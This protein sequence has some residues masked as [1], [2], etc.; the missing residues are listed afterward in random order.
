[1]QDRIFYSICFGFIVGVLVRSFIFINFYFLLFLV[2]LGSALILYFSLVKFKWGLI[3]AIFILALTLG[4]FRFQIADNRAPAVFESQVGHSVSLSGVVIDEPDIRQTN[5]KLTVEI[6]N[7]P[8]KTDVLVSA[9][10]DQ[11]FKYGDEINFTGKLKKPENFLTDQGKTF[12]YINYLRKDGILYL[13]NYPQIEIIS[14]NN[15]SKIKSALFFAKE[16]FLDEI[17]YIIPS[18]DSL[19]MGGLILGEKSDFDQTLR[20][21]FVNT[22]TIHI[23]ALSGYNVTIVAQWIM[24][25]FSLIPFVPKN[26]GISI[27]ILSIILFILM[28]GGSSTAIR[29]GIMATLALVARGTGRNYDVSRALVIAGVGMILLNPFVLVYDV[30]FQLSVL[31][32]VAVIFLSPKIEKYFMWMTEHFGLRE[33]VSLTV[34]AYIFVAP[35]ILYEMGNFS[36]VALP[37]N[38]LILPFIPLTM[39]MGFLTGF[40]GLVWNML[41]IPFAYFSY[42]LLHYELGVIGFFARLPFASLTFPDFPLFLTILIYIYFVYRL[43]GRNIREFFIASL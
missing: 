24:K 27:G 10:L 3:G 4:I 31:A 28:T 19:L 18:P 36:L 33:I 32:T 42:F 1:M 17:N 40:V 9:N 29:A 14:H 26:F 25:I 5:Q 41:A 16:K 39:L 38:V 43:F 12:D 23:V 30:S 11:D 7:G 21:S 8:D 13:V 34:A 15:G 22:G 37:T 2:L 35:F 20:A 6:Q